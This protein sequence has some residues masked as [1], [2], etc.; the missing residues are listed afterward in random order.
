M[1]DRYV[2]G[3]EIMKKKSPCRSNG[4]SQMLSGMSLSYP[5]L[6]TDQHHVRLR[7]RREQDEEG[8]KAAEVAA[9]DV[10]AHVP[11]NLQKWSNP[12][13]YPSGRGASSSNEGR[14]QSKG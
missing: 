13:T 10:V 4:A 6:S 12:R 11:T 5:T 7:E 1:D 2:K 3:R 14:V 8:D 9:S